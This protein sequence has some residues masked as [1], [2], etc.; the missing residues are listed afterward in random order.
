MSIRALVLLLV[1]LPVYA[2]ALALPQNWKKVGEADLKILWFD[3]YH[4][5]LL[6]PEGE[7]SG[8]EGPLLLRLNYKRNIQQT[9]LI[10]E[11]E[12]QLLKFANPARIQQWVTELES[13]WPSVKEGEQLAF[14]IDAS[15][16]GHFFYN[17][18]WIG[19]MQ[20]T[21]FGL[22]FISIWLSDKSSFP[23]LAKKLRGEVSD[24][25]AN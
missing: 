5:E 3:V 22:A 2:S 14:Q 20:D 25:K 4:A 23:R 8:V 19:S 16:R 9:D 17:G 1:A 15:G 10:E 24:E 6:V 13:F 12:E 18:K 11:T 7:F 21:D